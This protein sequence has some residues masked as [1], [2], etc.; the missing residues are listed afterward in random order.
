M[1]ECSVNRKR[2]KKTLV[3]VGDRES[4]VTIQTRELDSSDVDSSQPVYTFATV[5]QQWCGIE[6]LEGVPKFAKINIEDGATHL[7]W[8][9]YDAGLSAL[10]NRNTYI[11][12]DS[13][14]YKVLK[15]TNVNE[16]NETLVI[17]TTER[18]ATSEEATKA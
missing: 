18:G 9:D 1:S 6:T 8:T 16:K 5:R 17:Q 12:H 15:V 14:R 3:C 2:I 7:F 10:E 4:L 11:L 13:K